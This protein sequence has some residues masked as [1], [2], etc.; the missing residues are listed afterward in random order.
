MLIYGIWWAE[1]FKCDSKGARVPIALEICKHEASVCA[2]ASV[3]SVVSV[4][5]KQEWVV[6]SPSTPE[7]LSSP[8]LL[9]KNRDKR[10]ES[11]LRRP[12]NLSQTLS[13]SLYLGRIFG[14]FVPN[15]EPDVWVSLESKDVRCS[16][17]SGV[18]VW[19]CTCWYC[20]TVSFSC[21]IRWSSSASGRY[22]PGTTYPSGRF[23]LQISQP[24]RIGLLMKVQ[25]GHDQP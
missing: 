14:G 20:R 10:E 8:F 9:Q 13:A 11:Q 5:V 23:V 7:H 18:Q 3:C 22:P 21:W 16:G 1:Q 25:E 24:G 4:Q 6:L 19:L 17:C 15:M 12:L 2:P